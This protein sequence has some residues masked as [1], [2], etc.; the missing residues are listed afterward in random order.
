MH[1]IWEYDPR[2]LKYFAFASL[3]QQEL[4]NVT[5]NALFWIL[6]VWLDFIRVV[7]LPLLSRGIN[8]HCN[9]QSRNYTQQGLVNVVAA[10]NQL[11]LMC[12]AAKQ[13]HFVNN[14]WEKS[15]VP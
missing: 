7:V 14:L 5:L 2:A 11:D 10:T 13:K 3:D 15:E 8:F 6:D 12:S 9:K 1:L 4:F